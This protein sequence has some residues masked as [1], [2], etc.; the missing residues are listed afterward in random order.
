[1]KHLSVIVATAVLIVSLGIVTG[2]EYKSYQNREHAR[3]D[4]A[5]AQ[6]T[7]ER[8]NAAALQTKTQKRVNDLYAQCQIGM[9]AYKLLPAATRALKTTV[10]PNCGL[11]ILE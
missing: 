2:S 5:N 10:A 4:S 6:L 3:V 11:P 7:T 1:M 9:D 8:N